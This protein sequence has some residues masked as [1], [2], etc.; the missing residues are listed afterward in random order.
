MTSSTNDENPKLFQDS[1][2]PYDF[3]VHTVTRAKEVHK[4]D[5][6]I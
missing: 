6:W 3:Y 2:F 4:I 5:F 1:I